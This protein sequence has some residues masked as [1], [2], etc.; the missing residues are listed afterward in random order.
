MVL[1]PPS[2]CHT[3]NAPVTGAWLED[4]APGDRRFIKIGD[5]GLEE[6]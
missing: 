2:R 3:I 5:V 6:W 4:H 1:L